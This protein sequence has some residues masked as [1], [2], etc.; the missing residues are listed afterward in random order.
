LIV[1]LGI[2]QYKDLTMRRAKLF[3]NGRSQAVRLPKE[4]RFPGTEVLIERRGDEVVLRPV[5]AE[6]RAEAPVVRTFGDL[7]RRLREMGPAS[8]E[9]ERAITEARA[10]DRDWPE[11][12][13]C[14]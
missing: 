8:E 13:S 6:A 7:A 14:A 11:R 4:F 2:Y 5:A 10:R 12:D 1:I 3:A 9:F